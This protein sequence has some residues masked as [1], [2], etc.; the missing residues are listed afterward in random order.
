[1]PSSTLPRPE[2]SPAR[3][4]PGI[5]CCIL[6]AAVLAGTARPAQA[7]VKPSF[8]GLN[9]AFYEKLARSDRGLL[10]R[11]GLRTMRVTLNWSGVQPTQLKTD[12]SVPD[13]L[14]GQLAKLGIRPQPLIY[15]SPYWV[16]GGT[17]PI[18]GQP[19]DGQKHSTPPVGSPQAR[20]DWRAFVQGAVNRYKPGGAFWTG[21][22][23]QANP[24]VKPMPVKQWQVWNE[25]NIVR[26]FDPQP[27]VH[28]YAILL[29]DARKAIQAADPSARIALAGM[30]TDADLPE[31]KFLRKL[32]GVNGI[33]RD[34]DVVAVHPYG[35]SVANVRSDTAAIRH[36]MR[37]A[38]DGRTPIWVSET[39]W[40]SA[41]K[42]GH[43]NQGRRGQARMLT[44][45]MKMFAHHRGALGVNEVSW[46]V[47]R[48]PPAGTSVGDCTWCRYAGLLDDAGK[49]KPAWKAFRKLLG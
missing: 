26:S 21:P 29:K 6:L 2:R 39:S 15:S 23:A 18:T 14:F 41:P 32:Y 28:K 43:I 17:L 20:A 48:D 16:N 49:P 38:H 11:S 7:R 45:T 10:K 12:W 34:F 30:P 33:K 3:A 27:S 36:V 47:L 40:G 35:P 44:R 22:F 9:L 42:D 8:Y 24:G 31:A 25:P 19:T 13:A 5:A 1:M 4:L 37:R 46:F